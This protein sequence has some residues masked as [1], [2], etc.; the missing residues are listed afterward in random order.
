MTASAFYSNKS[1]NCCSTAAGYSSARIIPV[2]D[3]AVELVVSICVV[4][5]LPLA[6][7][8]TGM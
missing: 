4:C 6:V 3:T 7:V 5:L 8:L 2:L 1:F